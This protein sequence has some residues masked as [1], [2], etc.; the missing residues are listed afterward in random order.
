VIDVFDYD[1][2]RLYV[3]AWIKQRRS[4]SQRRLAEVLGLSSSQL[5]QILNPSSRNPR[6]LGPGHAVALVDK[7]EL[8][9]PAR[10]YMLALIELGSARDDAARED[11]AARVA[12]LKAFEFGRSLSTPQYR[13]FSAWH[14]LAIHELA[15]CAG[16]RPE[17]DWI[18]ST[19]VP[20][21]TPG[22]AAE[23]L[24]LLEELGLLE[25]DESGALHPRSGIVVDN[26]G[27]RGDVQRRATRQLHH[28]LL[29]RAVSALDDFGPDERLM[30]GACFAVARDD[31]P[32]LR[33]RLLSCV[34]EALEIGASGGD[35]RDAVFQVL[36]QLFPLSGP[37]TAGGSADSE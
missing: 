22:Q 17:P 21:I 6:R 10:T 20:S 7:L 8:E 14:H 29:A 26:E 5:S 19:L 33:R 27:H 2:F 36:V 4:R 30:N 11:A 9:G 13:L 24:E 31:L 32:H 15:C 3:R 1:D 25:R 16:F 23:S 37:T 35:R 18:A 34:Q 12:A 28:A